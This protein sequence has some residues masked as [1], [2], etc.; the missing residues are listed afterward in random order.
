MSNPKQVSATDAK[1][2]Q[3]VREA[4]LVAGL[5]QT[6]LGDLLGVTFQQVQKYEKGTNRIAPSRLQMVAEVTGKPIAWFFDDIVTNGNGIDPLA[7]LGTTREGIAL[8]RAFTSIGSPQMRHAI[9]TIAQAA[10]E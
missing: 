9:L 6:Q 10:A 3:R 1:V 5:S 4:R 7:V 2:A 8:A